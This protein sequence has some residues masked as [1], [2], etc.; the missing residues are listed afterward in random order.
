MFSEGTDGIT[1]GLR[2]LHLVSLAFNK[3]PDM[4]WFLF[5]NRSRERS[6]AT[7]RHRT[8]RFHLNRINTAGVKAPW[9]YVEITPAQTDHTEGE[10]T[11]GIDLDRINTTYVEAH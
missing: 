5:S 10:N 3:T 1:A 6:R 11:H 2:L 9:V 8:T 4:F 7:P